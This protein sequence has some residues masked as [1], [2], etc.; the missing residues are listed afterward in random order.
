MY[1]Q[2]VSKEIKVYGFNVQVRDNFDQAVA[3]VTEALKTEGFGVL[4]DID[5]K[6]TM[7]E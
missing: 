1:V 7:K 3:R 2:L 4:T 6:K 5:V